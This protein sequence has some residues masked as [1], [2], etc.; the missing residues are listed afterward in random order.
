MA[1][2]KT[3]CGDDKRKSDNIYI[4]IYGLGQGVRLNNTMRT[5]TPRVL[6]IIVLRVYILRFYACAYIMY[7]NNNIHGGCLRPAEGLYRRLQYNGMRITARS[8]L[9]S[10]G[11]MILLLLCFLRA[12]RP[13]EVMCSAVSP[14]RVRVLICMY[15]TCMGSIIYIDII[16]YV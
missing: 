9:H 10:D 16:L 12:H 7:N 5:H 6:Y 2:P 13:A 11:Q 15:I 1:F 4:I 14:P 8:V 3:R